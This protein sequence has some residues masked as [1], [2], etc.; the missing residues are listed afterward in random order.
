M[1]KKNIFTQKVCDAVKGYEGIA[2][3]YTQQAK[4]RVGANNA[5]FILDALDLSKENVS[6]R[7]AYYKLGLAA[8][9]NLLDKPPKIEGLD[10]LI[11]YTGLL[12]KGLTVGVTLTPEGKREKSFYTRDTDLLEELVKAGAIS[13]EEK[14]LEDLKKGSIEKKLGTGLKKAAL[15]YAR[16]DLEQ[17][18][19]DTISFKYVLPRFRQDQGSMSFKLYPYTGVYASSAVLY[20]EIKKAQVRVTSAYPEV[21]S[22]IVGVT[23]ESVLQVYKGLKVSMQDIEEVKALVT[24]RSSAQVG[25]MCE[26]NSIK[27]FDIESSL[28]DIG[29]I[30]INIFDITGLQVVKPT[31]ISTK[32]SLVD[33]GD[34]KSIYRTR[35]NSWRLAQYEVFSYC[36]TSE[37]ANIPERKGILRKWQQDL[38]NLQLYSVMESLPDLF[39][40]L[41]KGLAAKYRLK[42]VEEK[43]LEVVEL[44]ED[45][46]KRVDQLKE[47]MSTGVVKLVATSKKGRD[48]QYLCTDDEDLLRK[49]LGANY[50]K[51][52]ESVRT[53]LYLAR[54]EAEETGA[55]LVTTLYAYNLEGRIPDL[56]SLVGLP[57]AEQLSQLDE[58]PMKTRAKSSNVYLVPFKRLTATGEDDFYGSI[59]VRSIISLYY[60][61]KKK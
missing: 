55:D 5:P 21:V 54:R 11:L 1:I 3:E 48:K 15:A 2:K 25:W 34:L 16:L 60:G 9:G 35:I 26:K 39:G 27:C 18:H 17:V 33:T 32:V 49:K 30:N 8:L 51:K 31:Q 38:S 24:A 37:A 14:L 43:N 56:D 6:V 45:Y 28:Y 13:N 10:A 50:A 47:L 52:Y 20:N 61:K 4:T 58:V 7:Q 53:R 46:M 42:G 19:G 57:L 41:Q 12:T 23:P 36:D 29:T 40:D 22:S 44:E 59:D